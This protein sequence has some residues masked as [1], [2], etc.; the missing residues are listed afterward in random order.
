M[1]QKIYVLKLSIV[2][3]ELAT[4]D[5]F[6]VNVNN[7]HHHPTITVKNHH[8]SNSFETSARR[9]QMVWSDLFTNDMS[10]YREN[11][12]SSFRCISHDDLSEVQTILDH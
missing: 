4:A 12:T 3:N 1:L 6:G 8:H 10:D 11:N 7:R 9:R 2:E 5:I